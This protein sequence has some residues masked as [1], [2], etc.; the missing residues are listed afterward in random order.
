MAMRLDKYLSHLQIGSRKDIKLMVKQKRLQVDGEI[1][2]DAGMAIAEPARITLDGQI[3][4]G[5]LEVY[6]L[7]NK[8]AGVLTATTDAHQQTVLDLIAL[9]DRR[10]NLAPVGRLDKDTT[11][12]LLLTTDGAMGHRLLA[13]K[14]HVPK[15]YH[16]RLRQPLTDAAIAQLETGIAFKDFTSAPAQVTRL[17]P[18]EVLITIHEGKFHQV[19]RMFLAVDNEVLTLQ[20]QQMGPLKLDPNLALGAYRALTTAELSALQR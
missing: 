17:E 4:D 5:A 9:A 10:P 11:G 3:I 20:R 6:Y 7:M 16:V 1:V 13:P 2:T 18:T 14:N 12:L 15:V 19:K 8:P